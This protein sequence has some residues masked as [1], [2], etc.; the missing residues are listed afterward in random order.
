[1]SIC[2]FYGVLY[3]M[4]TKSYI[5]NISLNFTSLFIVFLYIRRLVYTLGINVHESISN[6]ETATY[7][8]VQLLLI[9]SGDIELNSG[10]TNLREHNVSVLHCNMRS[11]RNKLDII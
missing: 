2:L 7:I 9:L 6:M 1:M 3:G 5:G 8:I 10:P 4:V 11:I